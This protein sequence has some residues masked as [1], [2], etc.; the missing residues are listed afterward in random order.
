MLIHQL[1]HE[2]PR[3]P[4]RLNDRIPRDLD[5]ICMK[6][7]AKLPQRR[8]ATAKE[9]ADDLRRYLRGEPCR[10]RPVGRLE[11]GWLWVM[12]NRAL[13]AWVAAAALLLFAV[14]VGSVLFAVRETTHA[15]RLGV[16]LEKSNYLLAANLFDRGLTLCEDGEVAHGMLLMARGLAA[17]PEQRA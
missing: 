17:V 15:N 13:A 5:T 7:L 14:S 9:M 3:P 1:L 11:R 2:D 6:A 16:A 8:F 12:R 10:A 4:R